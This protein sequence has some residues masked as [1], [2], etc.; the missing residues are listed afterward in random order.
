MSST[1]EISKNKNS[2]VWLF[3]A[4]GVS[5]VFG[6]VL[7]LNLIVSSSIPFKVDVTEDKIHTLSQGTK[8][9]LEGLDTPVTVSF[10]VSKDKDNMRPELIPFAKRVDS[11]LKEY[12]RGSSKGLIEIERVD[13]S[14]DSEEED[15]AKLNNLQGI[16][17]RLNE[18]A[19]LGLTI[20]CLDRK[21]SIPIIDPNREQM[22]E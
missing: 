8:D 9:V 13:P 10:F 21:S 18:P 7:A 1:K 12:E 20:T 16:P 19:Y 17:G 2:Q 14:P 5:L 22:L 3:S 4:I 15:R 6:I 11:L